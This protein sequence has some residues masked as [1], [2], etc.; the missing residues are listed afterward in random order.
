MSINPKAAKKLMAEV[1]PC[2]LAGRVLGASGQLERPPGKTPRE[3]L[4][5]LS[6]DDREATMRGAVAALTYM[7]ECFAKAKAA[8]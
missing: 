8:Q 5:Q 3:L 7:S 4:A 6:A 2:E 1:D